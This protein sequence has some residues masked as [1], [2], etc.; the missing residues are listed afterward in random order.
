LSL[1]HVT[2]VKH[3]TIIPFCIKHLF[4]TQNIAVYVSSWHG[5]AHIRHSGQH[6]TIGM[7]YGY[8]DMIVSAHPGR[9]QAG[10]QVSQYGQGF[11]VMSDAR[12]AGPMRFESQ[13]AP[14]RDFFQR[15][16]PETTGGA[17]G[18]CK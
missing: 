4:N 7:M 12:Q 11:H 6:Y 1:S 8:V 2:T 14:G 17:G 15:V 18:G 13:G 3:T 16:P 9:Q 5:I 10:G